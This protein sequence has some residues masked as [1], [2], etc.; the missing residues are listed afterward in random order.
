MK[1][2]QYETRRVRWHRPQHTSIVDLPSPIN[3]FLA[4]IT[5]DIFEQMSNMTNLYAVQQNI[6]RFSS[7]TPEEMKKFIGIHIVMGNLKFP[8]VNM[9]WNSTT[10]VQIVHE[11]MSIR[12]FYKLRQTIHLVDITSRPEN[13]NDR[14]WKVRC[15]YDSL[16]ARC[17]ELELETNLCVDEQIVPFKGNI[18]VKQYIKNKPKKWGIKIYV[19]A[20]QSGLI[21]DFIIYQG[22]TTEMKTMYTH[23]G[24]AAGIVMQLTERI[25]EPNHG[26]FFDNFFSTYQL[27]QY[28]TAKSIFAV[29]TVRSDRFANPKLPSDKEMKTRGRGSSA[30]CVSKDGIV[31]TKWFDNR[32]VVT[33]SNFIGIGNEDS[34][35]RWDKTAKEYI[36]VSRPEAIKFYNNNMGGVD[37]HDFL[38]SLYRSY[39]RSKKWTVRMISHAVDLALVN[40]WLE[41]KNQASKL[42]ISK[43]HTLDLLA[44]RQSVA[45]TL[46]LSKKNAK[47]G[48]PSTSRDSSEPSEKQPFETRPVT[49]FRYDGYDH[50]PLV[51][52][53]KDNSRCK[54]ELCKMKTHIFCSKCKLH[55]CLMKGRNCFY[56]FHKK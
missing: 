15:M 7:T 43:Q 52:D 41:Y 50:L 24:A 47:R 1:D 53:K 16:R 13:N 54:M 33:C 44:F 10:R 45:E 11:A 18:N 25:T 3:F 55:L 39:V 32:S 4:Y 37:K 9:Y 38:L 48:R 12:R 30:V 49:E 20:G 17:L 26:L 31:L 36:Q 28:L 51:D 29:G 46:I 56:N 5:Q 34:C 19:L 2:V 42:G 21:Y 40:S 14:L 35:R 23:C 27:F 22:A 8:R 6:P